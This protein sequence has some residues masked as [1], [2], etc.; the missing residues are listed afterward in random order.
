LKIAGTGRVSDPHPFQADPDPG[1][2][3]YAA[4]DPMLNFFK[5]KKIV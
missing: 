3:I 1:F 2:R 5:K 4:P